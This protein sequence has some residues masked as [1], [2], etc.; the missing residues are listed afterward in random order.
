MAPRSAC[1]SVGERRVWDP[2]GAGAE[3]ATL[4]MAN[5]EPDP[6]TLLEEAGAYHRLAHSRPKDWL[7]ARDER[8]RRV[9]RL[10]PDVWT[11]PAIAE[12]VGC[13]TELIKHIILKKKGRN[14]DSQL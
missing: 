7:R 4:T 11:Y 14:R 9:R 13:S 12:R 1:S 5:E 8:I 6:E 3:P 10:D 2:E